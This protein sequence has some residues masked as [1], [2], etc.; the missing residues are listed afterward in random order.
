MNIQEQ[1]INTSFVD[2]LWL[3][4]RRLHSHEIAK[5][6]EETIV[7]SSGRTTFGG[8]GSELVL[9]KQKTFMKLR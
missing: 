4:A 6:K 7:Q 8:E 2:R 5:A 1:T 3:L 9:T